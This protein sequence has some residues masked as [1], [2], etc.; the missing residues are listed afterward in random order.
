[1]LLTA[2]FTFDVSA[3][4]LSE[5]FWDFGLASRSLHG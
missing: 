5:V 4:G 1:M 2:D 3:V